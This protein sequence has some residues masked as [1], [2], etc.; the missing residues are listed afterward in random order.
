MK[1]GGCCLHIGDQNGVGQWRQQIH[2]PHNRRAGKPLRRNVRVND[3]RDRKTAVQRT[4]GRDLRKVGGPDERD[5]G[6][7]A[8][9]A[10]RAAMQSAFAWRHRANEYD[11]NSSVSRDFSAKPR[12]V[13]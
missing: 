1:H 12:G 13:R 2:I 7:A 11:M 6:A 4:N 8:R 5:P 10:S 9:A 3:R